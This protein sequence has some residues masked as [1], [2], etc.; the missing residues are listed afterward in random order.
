MYLYGYFLINFFIPL[1][2]AE[3]LHEKI[4][5]RQ[6][7]TAA[8]RKRDPVLPGW[9]VLHVIAGSNLWKVYNTARIP[10]KRDRVSYQLTGIML[11]PTKVKLDEIST[12]PARTGFTLL[13]HVEIKFCPSKAGQFSTKY[14]FRF[15]CIFFKFFLISISVYDVENP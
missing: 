3:Q 6:S 11:S 13:L 1:K 14:L 2:R 8:V 7:N 12:R 5:S 10:A 4:S 9:I 15:A